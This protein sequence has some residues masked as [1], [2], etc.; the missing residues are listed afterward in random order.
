MRAMLQLIRVKHWVKNGFVFLPIFFSLRLFEVNSFI[1][2]CAAF[3]VFSV[4]ASGIYVLNDVK[5]RK[6]D[7]HH[8]EKKLRPIASGKV[9]LSSAI[10]FASLLLMFG[11][12]GAFILDLVIGWWVL[13]YAILNIAYTNFL[14][15]IPIVDVMCIAVGFVMRLFVGGA[16]IHAPVSMWLVIVAFLLACFLGFGKRREDVVL[17]GEGGMETRIMI[18]G[19]SLEFL[20]AAMIIMSTLTLVAYLIYSVSSDIIG[21]ARSHT[22]YISAVFMLAGF[23]RYLELM[24]TEKVITSPTDLI[25]RDRFLQ[26]CVLGYFLLVGYI[27]YT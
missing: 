13:A 3:L 21:N 20:N 27:L 1:S 17:K 2:V 25:F 18:K 22:F 7:S 23:L 9:S 16:V 4:T 14:K 19:Y 6:E 10:V 8:T 5:D 24:L 26:V 11:I 12:A 15:K